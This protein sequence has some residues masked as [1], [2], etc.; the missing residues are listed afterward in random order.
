VARQPKVHLSMPRHGIGLLG[1]T[2]EKISKSDPAVLTEYGHR[3][4]DLR[5]R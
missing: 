5:G 4:E 1:L 2:P 3:I